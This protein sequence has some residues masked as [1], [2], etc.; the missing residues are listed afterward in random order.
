MAVEPDGTSELVR[1][2]SAIAT[3]VIEQSLA[4]ARKIEVAGRRV[5]V[6]PRRPA[7]Y[8]Y[9]YLEQL[10]GLGL[11]GAEWDVI[12]SLGARAD[13]KGRILYS[14]SQVCGELGIDRADLYRRMRR[15]VE[16]G[17]FERT[18]RGA[19]RL[20]PRMMWH[21]SSSAQ[22]QLL[23]EQGAEGLRTRWAEEG[24]QVGN[25]ETEQE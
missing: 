2:A 8:T 10:V 3:E 17:V 24:F 12:F 21:G 14:S 25:V 23:M 16:A 1:L 9:V 11:T 13:Q 18:G 20:N 15:I 6:K 22:V 19:L 4:K 7:G 5:N